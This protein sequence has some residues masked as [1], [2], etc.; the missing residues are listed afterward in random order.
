MSLPGSSLKKGLE[1]AFVLEEDETHD[2]RQPDSHLQ[3]SGHFGRGNATGL[4]GTET[5]GGTTGGRTQ[6]FGKRKQGVADPL[7]TSHRASPKIPRR[8]GAPPGRLGEQTA[9]QRHRS[10]R[11]PA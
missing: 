8:I 7:G 10:D 5:A 2:R 6:G 3:T 11:F 1:R 9:D 4:A